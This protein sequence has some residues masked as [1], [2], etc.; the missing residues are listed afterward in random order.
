[1]QE[2]QYQKRL[3]RRVSWLDLP[4]TPRHSNESGPSRVSLD[5]D[6]VSSSGEQVPLTKRVSS[7]PAPGSNSHRS[8]GKKRD[9]ARRIW[10][11]MRLRSKPPGSQET[12]VPGNRDIAGKSVDAVQKT[13]L[14]NKRSIGNDT[15]RSLSL[16]IQNPSGIAAP[17]L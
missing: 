2:Q 16:S 14:R 11:D 17:W 9:A 15:L 7:A 6:L 3:D 1:M 12:M 5:E 10:S 4:D 13:A 8:P